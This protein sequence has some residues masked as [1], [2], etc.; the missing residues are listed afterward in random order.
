MLSS[1][2][3]SLIFTD[4]NL[5]QSII[6]A[7]KKSK[8]FKTLEDDSVQ[9]MCWKMY[10]LRGLVWRG[11]WRFLCILH[12]HYLLLWSRSWCFHFQQLF[13]IQFVCLNV[14]TMLFQSFHFC[15]RCNSLILCNNFKLNLWFILVL[16]STSTNF[17]YSFEFE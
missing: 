10:F 17:C 4:K 8:M 13:L 12:L 6:S 9:K 2:C 3:L 5:S 11:I 14:L 1:P 7:S 16:P 15:Q